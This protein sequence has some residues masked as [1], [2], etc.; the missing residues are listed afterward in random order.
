MIGN[1]KGINNGYV[2]NVAFPVLN[3]Q[4]GIPKGDN[5]QQQK[6]NVRNVALGLT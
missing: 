5:N 4:C 1:R 3:W 2:R 6:G